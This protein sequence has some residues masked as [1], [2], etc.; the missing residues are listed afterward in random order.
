MR[1]ITNP[2]LCFTQGRARPYPPRREVS[3][4]GSQ[5]FDLIFLTMFIAGTLRHQLTQKASPTPYRFLSR[6]HGYVD[7][8]ALQ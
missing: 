1:P 5:R 8:V 4:C 7:T 2:V 3:Y 6:D